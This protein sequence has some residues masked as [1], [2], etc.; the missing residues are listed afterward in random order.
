MKLFVMEFIMFHYKVM[1][2]KE[3]YFK[4]WKLRKNLIKI[5]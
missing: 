1:N 5:F 2:Y 4:Q 3:K